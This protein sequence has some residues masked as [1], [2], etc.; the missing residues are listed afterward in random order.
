[1]PTR[2]LSS[3]YHRFMRAG[4]DVR[5]QTDVAQEGVD[6]GVDRPNIVVIVTDDMR[7]SDWQALPR[8]R[9]RVGDNG[10]TFPNFFLTTPICSPS[11]ATIL[12]GQYAHN[13]QVLRNSGKNA[14][15]AR[16]KQRN[17][18]EQSISAAL[19]DVGY[20][21]GL[22]GKFLN[23]MPEKGNVPGG[24]DQWMATSEL[25]YYRPQMNDNG[26][27]RDFKKKKQYSTDILSARAT[28]FISSTPT[29][30]PLFLYFAP[31]APHGPSTPARRDRGSFDGA[32]RERSPDFNESDV[33]DKPGYIR[34]RNGVSEGKMDD[35]EQKRL[36]SLIATDDA[37]EA[38]LDAM[39]EEG[40]LDNTYVFVLSDNG[41]TMGSHRWATKDVPY[42]ESTR[43]TMIVS[44]PMF[45]GGGIDSRVAANIDIAPTIAAIAGVSFETADGVS[46]VNPPSRDEIVL[47]AWSVSYAALRTERYLYVENASGE[48]ELY[49]YENDPFELDNLLAD[50]EGHTPSS[51][52]E[53]VA[54][55][56][57]PRLDALRDCAGATC[58]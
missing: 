38:I 17:L 35:L 12:T 30:T 51:E 33:S 50:W 49:D 22:F 6:N 2:L 19:H 56:L 42:D 53:D 34:R 29:E 46:L 11:R 1:M 47:E 58:I 55:G 25:T 4:D 41:H 44:G 5:Y 36:E 40:R 15:Y 57:K 10:T 39:Q 48:R 16:F 14:G 31:K 8:A 7:D 3:I 32:H 43:V 52:A 18:G 13:H 28:Q 45:A 23:G 21:T 26:K 27:E 54:S 9:Q 37:V 20:R 24:W